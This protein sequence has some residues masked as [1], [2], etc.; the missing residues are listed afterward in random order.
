VK[1]RAPD[2]LKMSVKPKSTR[3]PTF[4]RKRCGNLCPIRAHLDQDRKELRWRELK[5]A[6]REARRVEVERDVVA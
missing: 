1:D 5:E 2:I 4:E 3:V 6:G